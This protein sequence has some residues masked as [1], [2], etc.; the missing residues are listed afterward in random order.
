M[1]Y[2]VITASHEAAEHVNALLAEM[3]NTAPVVILIH[4]DSGRIL[5]ANTLASE[6]HGYTPEEFLK[7]NLLDLVAPESTDKI[8]ARSDSINTSGRGFF[9]VDHLTRSGKRIPLEVSVKRVA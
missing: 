9:E 3:L 5:F 6:L 4:D 8:A 2:E 7:L 1:L